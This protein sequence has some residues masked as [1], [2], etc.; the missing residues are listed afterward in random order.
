M[1]QKQLYVILIKG[2]EL[3]KIFQIMQRLRNARQYGSKTFQYNNKEIKQFP[4]CQMIMSNKCIMDNLKF[5]ARPVNFE[6]PD[7]RNKMK[8]ILLQNGSASLDLLETLYGV[9]TGNYG[10]LI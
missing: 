4:T 10:I 2:D 9:V 7:D 6:V 8:Q 1:Q 3:T 5:F